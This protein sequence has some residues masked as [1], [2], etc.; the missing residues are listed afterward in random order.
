MVRRS[1]YSS[2]PV[3]SAGD[4]V[5]AINGIGVHSITDWN[6]ALKKTWNGTYAEVK[7]IRNGTEG[8]ALIK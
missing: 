4:T 1:W 5:T 8:S 7:Y 6:E 2:N 3:L